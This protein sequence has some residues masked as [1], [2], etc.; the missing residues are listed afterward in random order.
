MMKLQTYCIVFLFCA[1][2]VIPSPAQDKLAFT[3]LVSFNGTDGSDPVGVLVQHSDGNFYGTTAGGGASGHGTIFRITPA[4][5]LTTLYSFCSQSNCTDGAGPGGL[6]LGTDGNFYGTTG[7]GG[8]YSEG[9]FFKMTVGHTPGGVTT[10]YSFQGCSG[11]CGAGDLVL[12]SDGNFYGTTYYSGSYGTLFRITPS[13]VLTTL[14]NFD[15]SDGWGPDAPLIQA[16]DGNL[17]GTTEYGGASDAGTVFKISP[18]LPYTLTTLY[19]FCSQP[20]CA[21][22][23]APV[24][25][26]QASDG[27]FYGPTLL[28][29]NPSCTDGCGTVFQLIPT[30]NP[31]WTLTT[32]HSFSG[33]DGDY[34]EA[35]LLLGSDRNFYGTTYGGGAYDDGTVFKIT[36]AGTLT[37]LHSFD[38]YDEY[39]PYAGLLQT[40]F[41]LLYGTASAGGA[42]NA[43]SIYSLLP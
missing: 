18:E 12:G 6:V 32:L 21:D 35:P 38:T 24:G 7:G 42:D 40:S 9:T 27:N 28:G 25:V 34:P 16:R 3:T 36:P 41:G 30:Q 43:G 37:T 29:G 31:P 4:G 5:A 11:G 20:N 10:L 15:G 8:T 17:Y 23:I 14:H 33:P 39:P 2:A 13:G 22:G 19:S 1:V 26:V